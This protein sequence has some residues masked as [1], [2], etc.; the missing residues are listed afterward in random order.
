MTQQ[1]LGSEENQRARLTPRRVR[2]RAQQV[3]VLRG[4]RAVSDAPVI[5]G[6]Q[7]QVALNACAGVFRP[8]SLVAVWQEQHESRVLLP[9]GACGGDKLVNNHLSNIRKVTK[10]RLPEHESFGGLHAVAV[11]EAEHSRFCERAVVNGKRGPRLGQVLEGNVR[12][13]VVLVVQHSVTVTERAA[14][15]ILASQA[16]GCTFGEQRSKS[17]RFGLPPI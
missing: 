6:G 15:A 11:F 5:L 2:L 3:K 13:A 9:L 8:L 4:G 1:A 14:L 10:L 7:L 17:Q 12:L 16:N